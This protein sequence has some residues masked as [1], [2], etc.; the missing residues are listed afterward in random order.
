M[1][2][3]IDEFAGFVIRIH[4]HDHGPPHVHVRK[5]NAELRIYLDDEHSP[6]S[7][8]GHMKLADARVAVRIVAKRRLIYLKQWEE[9]DPQ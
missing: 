2:P 8:F 6:E 5:G 9:I 4:S 3:S 1:A 7:V